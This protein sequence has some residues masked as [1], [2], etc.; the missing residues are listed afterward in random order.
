MLHLVVTSG[1]CNRLFAIV[2]AMRYCR[3]TQQELTIHWKI[4]VGR[5]GVKYGPTP[6]NQNEN[7]NNFFEDIPNVYHTTFNEETTIKELEQQ[8]VRILYDGRKIIP[9]YIGHNFPPNFRDLIF[10]ALAFPRE[11]NVMVIMPTRPFGFDDDPMTNYIHYPRKPGVRR[12]KSNYEKEL[13]KFARKLK[14]SINILRTISTQRQMLFPNVN[15]RR[16]G[17]HVRRTDLK[18]NVSEQQLM[19]KIKQY[20]DFFKNKCYLF[21]CSDDYELERRLV[22]KFNFLTYQDLSKTFNDL[23]GIQKS[24]VDLYLLSSCQY[25]IGT[26]GSSFSYYAWI[27]GDDDHIFEI[28]S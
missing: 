4:P 14:P 9:E 6:I 25:V 24:L 16:I 11:Q 19:E 20:V 21:L 8:N 5:Y 1:L 13:G 27:L 15:Q 10:Q 18:T 2:S 22:Q 23:P 12:I 17:F 28:H 3:Q 26:A 7:L